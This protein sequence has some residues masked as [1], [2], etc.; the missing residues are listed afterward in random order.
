MSFVNYLLSPHTAGD[1]GKLA[2]T[3]TLDTLVSLSL[4]SA[5]S[6][7]LRFADPYS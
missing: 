7:A 1:K 2:A 5:C 3:S 4:L 6:C